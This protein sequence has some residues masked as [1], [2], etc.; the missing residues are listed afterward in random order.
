MKASLQFPDAGRTATARAN[1]IVLRRS[2]DAGKPA[3]LG[4]LRS[5]RDALLVPDLTPR[6]LTVAVALG[7]K[8]RRCCCSGPG[9]ASRAWPPAWKN[10]SYMLRQR[11][12]K[13]T[14]KKRRW[15]HISDR[16]RTVARGRAGE[17][18]LLSLERVGLSLLQRTCGI[19]TATQRLQGAR[20]VAMP[21]HDR[22][23]AQDAV[24]PARQARDIPRWRRHAP[25]W[26]GRRNRGEK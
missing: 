14:L 17:N 25:V 20:A 12:V 23:D 11:G 24:G 5:L 1:S 2:P 18:K 9:A 15:R 4:V 7:I 3:Y 16:R 19:A 13:V 22:G 21:R 10:T 8:S 26:V 6:D